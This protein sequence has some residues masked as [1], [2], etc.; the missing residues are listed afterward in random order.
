MIHRPIIVTLQVCFLFMAFIPLHALSAPTD[1][2]YTLGPTTSIIIRPD[3]PKNNLSIFIYDSRL[4]GPFQIIIGRNSLAEASRVPPI[5]GSIIL[6]EPDFMPPTPTATIKFDTNGTTRR[7]LLE[8]GVLAIR[9]WSGTVT[10][11]PIQGILHSLSPVYYTFMEPSLSSEFPIRYFSFGYVG[12]QN[13]KYHGGYILVSMAEGNGKVLRP[14]GS[15]ATDARGDFYSLNN[16]WI[17]WDVGYE[18]A[19]PQI[20]STSQQI[21]DGDQRLLLTIAGSVSSLSSRWW[22]AFAMPFDPIVPIH[23]TSQTTPPP[24]IPQENGMRRLRQYLADLRI[25]PEK[26]IIDRS[27]SGLPNTEIEPLA[28]SL[29]KNNQDE[30]VSEIQSA[31]RADE[32]YLRSETT[33]QWASLEARRILQASDILKQISIDGDHE[34]IF[35]DLKPTS[36][37]FEHNEWSLLTIGFVNKKWR[38]IQTKVWVVKSDKRARDVIQVYQVPVRQIS[39]ELQLLAD[40]MLVTSSGRI[41]HVKFPTVATCRNV[42]RN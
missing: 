1:I 10:L 15:M 19:K 23:T 21:L 5:I 26:L 13:T 37:D 30:A 12:S 9:H 33:A 42:F 40:G 28:S 8:Q 16:N 31:L 41:I 36:P 29:L 14:K 34:I 35:T 11:F 38:R 39:S 18:W 7:N 27:D 22:T 17:W 32:V 24:L 25:N 6:P 20:R 2:Q 3:F 4:K